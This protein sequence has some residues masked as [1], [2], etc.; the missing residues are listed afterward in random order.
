MSFIIEN[1]II[2]IIVLFIMVVWLV[3]LSIQLFTVYQRDRMVNETA[4]RGNIT[5]L[6]N[7]CA[8]NI[9]LVDTKLEDTR[10]YQG[11]IRNQLQ[12]AIQRVGVVRFDAFDDIGGKLSF[13]V[14]LLNESGDGVVI[15]TINGRQESRS[16]AKPIKKGSSPHTLSQEEKG[17]IAR[18]MGA[19]CRSNKRFEGDYEEI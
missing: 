12:G 3:F 9:S 17:A 15:S 18:A 14:A 16:Y 10:L 2:L 6:I 11:Q 7:Q 13:V 5:S 8:R 19:Q 4:K 1:P